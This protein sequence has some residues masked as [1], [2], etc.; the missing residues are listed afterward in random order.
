MSITNCNRNY[1]RDS[2]NY[3]RL[4]ALSRMIG[5]SPCLKVF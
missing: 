2:N 5:W 1:S 4:I 3:S